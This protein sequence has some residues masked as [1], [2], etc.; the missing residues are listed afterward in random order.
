MIR[1]VHKIFVLLLFL[2]GSFLLTGSRLGSQQEGTQTLP[3]SL[4]P[5]PLHLAVVD[6]DGDGSEEL[7]SV[8]N[9]SLTLVRRQ[10]PGSGLDPEPPA[11]KPLNTSIPGSASLWTVADLNN[12]GQRQFLALEDGEVLRSLSLEDGAL[13]WSS[14]ILEGL[15]AN[16]LLPRGVRPASFVRDLD[17]DGLQDLV[18]PMGSRVRLLFGKQGGGFRFG[19]DLEVATRLELD[20]GGS[21]NGLMG[22]VSRRLQVPHLEMQDLS[23]D[24]QPDLQIS[25]GTLIRQYISKQGQL[26]AEPTRTVNLSDF[27]EKLPDLEWDPSNLTGMVSRFAVWDEWV[28]LNLDGRN[29]L[30]LLMGGTVLIYLGGPDGVNVRS[31]PAHVLKAS[32]NVMYALAVPV[33]KDELPD[34]ILIKAEDVSLTQLLSWLVFSVSVEVDVLAFKGLGRG[35]FGRK[36][37]PESK[38]GLE[39]EAPSVLKLVDKRDE[40]DPLRRTVLRLADFDGDGQASDLVMLD[41]EGAL[42]GYRHLVPDPSVTERHTQRFIQDI[43]RSDK[44]LELSIQTL[45]GWLFGRASILVSLTHGKRPDFQ[46]PADKDWEAPHAMMVADFDGDRRDEVLFLRRTRDLEKNGEKPSRGLVGFL[47]DPGQEN[48]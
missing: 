1:G 6:L 5:L 3:V 42:K 48:P 45:A 19:P 21:G 33:D 8:R 9:H 43:L 4:E 2:V 35:R 17:Q 13:V 34:L 44:V 20:T 26:P 39:V 29:D 24:G 18:I 47:V 16:R 36:P 27:E 31:R 28:D 22:R 30:I 41:H 25:A 23:G 37:M 7:L 11:D 38:I 32:G 40:A 12:D 10:I 46:V 15:G 14:P